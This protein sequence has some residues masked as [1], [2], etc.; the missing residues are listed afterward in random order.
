VGRAIRFDT[1]V[2]EGSSGRNA[3]LM[4]SAVGTDACVRAWSSGGNNALMGKS[5]VKIIESIELYL[6]TK[7]A[8]VSR[9]LILTFLYCSLLFFVVMSPL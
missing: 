7:T 8:A 4:G 9:K 6:P 3:A 1:R 5:F 2:W